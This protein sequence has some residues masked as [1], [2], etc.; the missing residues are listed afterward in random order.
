MTQI[1]IDIARQVA[2]DLADI[3]VEHCDEVMI[4]GSIRRGKSEVKDAELVIR[5]VSAWGER[6]WASSRSLADL[7]SVPERAEK[8]LK[9]LRHEYAEAKTN[10]ATDAKLAAMESRG[11]NIDGALRREA[12]WWVRQGMERLAAAEADLEG[13]AG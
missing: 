3:L 8:E 13:V 12:E 2:A 1:R 11:R 4:A 9:K 10:G 5:L 7:A 6:A